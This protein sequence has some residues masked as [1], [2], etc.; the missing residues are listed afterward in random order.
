MA[1]A[2]DQIVAQHGAFFDGLVGLVL[3]KHYFDSETEPLNLRYMKKDARAEAKKQFKEQY[4]QNKKEKLKPDAALT[5]L[6]VQKQK[7]QAAASEGSKQQQ[8][9]GMP[10]LQLSNEPALSREQLREKLQK[11][12]EV[13]GRK[14]IAAN[15]AGI[16]LYCT[17]TACH[18]SSTLFNALCR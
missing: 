13:S 16:M 7:R 3:A 12:L 14:S 18:G 2:L 17:A 5:A 11:K 9:K 10:S 8:P 6:D 15:A 4:K 1:V